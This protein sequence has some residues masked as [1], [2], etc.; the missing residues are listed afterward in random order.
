MKH[1]NAPDLNDQQAIN[2]HVVYL[3]HSAKNSLGVFADS[4]SDEQKNTA[5]AWLKQHLTSK[6]ST[7]LAVKQH[8][9]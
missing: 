6:K 2:A 9:K 7:L 3:Y 5:R 8:K 4:L 1:E